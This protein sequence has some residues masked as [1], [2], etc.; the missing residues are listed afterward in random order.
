[1][2]V[3]VIERGAADFASLERLFRLLFFLGHFYLI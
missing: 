1:M 2:R 3:G